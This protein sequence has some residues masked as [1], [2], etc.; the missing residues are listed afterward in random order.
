MDYPWEI[1]PIDFEAKKSI[2][3]DIEIEILL[4]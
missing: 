2:A 1:F 4:P 3:F